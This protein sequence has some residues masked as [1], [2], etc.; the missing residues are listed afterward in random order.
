ML[1]PVRKLR[2]A[3]R[4]PRRSDAPAEMAAVVGSICEGM[5]IVG[6][7]LWA[8][9]LRPEGLPLTASATATFD[10]SFQTPANRVR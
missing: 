9:E 3:L 5:R 6:R 7:A 8:L 10:E 1:T 4:T 2:R